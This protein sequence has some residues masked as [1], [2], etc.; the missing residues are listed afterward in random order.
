MVFIKN[1]KEFITKE[2]RISSL[3]SNASG[4]NR[5]ELWYK[6]RTYITIFIRLIAC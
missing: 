2:S 3:F 1:E 6:I 4:T 5:L